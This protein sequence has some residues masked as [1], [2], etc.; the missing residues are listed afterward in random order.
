MTSQ[1]NFALMML[2]VNIL[3]SIF[4]LRCIMAIFEQA[5]RDPRKTVGLA[6]I[7]GWATSSFLRGMCRYWSTMLS[8]IFCGIGYLMALFDDEAGFA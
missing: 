4:C 6:V 5:R 2:M 8:G 7:R 3:L 1:D